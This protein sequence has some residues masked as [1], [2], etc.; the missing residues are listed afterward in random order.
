MVYMA[1]SRMRTCYI[2]FKYMTYSIEKL[3]SSLAVS[4]R[5]CVKPRSKE[6]NLLPT[7]WWPLQYL[8]LNQAAWLSAAHSTW[9]CPLSPVFS[10]MTAVHRD[11]L[12]LASYAPWPGVQ[13]L[14]PRGQI[15]SGDLP[16]LT[17]GWTPHNLAF[18]ITFMLH[19]LLRTYMY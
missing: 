9:K 5:A 7:W 11:R 2:L 1:L 6:Q 10:A 16:L 18:G 14:M 15:V 19:S 3:V 17:D 13:P 12:V 4:S 8:P